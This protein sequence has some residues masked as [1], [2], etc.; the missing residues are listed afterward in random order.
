MN[1]L[2][3]ILLWASNNKTLQEKLPSVYF[4]KKAVNRFMPGENFEDAVT[5]AKELQKNGLGVVFTC[6]GENLTN[7]SEAEKVKDHY[8]KVLK[9]INKENLNAEISIKLTQLG[10]DLSTDKTIE[11][12]NELTSR[13]KELNNFVWIDMES[14]KYTQSTL[15][16]YKLIQ[17][18]YGN[19]GICLQ[20]YLIRTE[21]DV[22]ELIN[23][24]SSIRLVKGAYKE[25][26]DITLQSKSEVDNNYIKLSELLISKSSRCKVVFGTHDLKIINLLKTQIKKS[27]QSNVNYEFHLLYGIKTKEQLKLNKEGFNVK[28]LISYG[29]AWYPWYMR[30]L[31]ERPANIGFVL[32]NIFTR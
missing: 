19:C 25:L 17:N 6:L 16:F 28:V 7:L 18:Q 8:L 5:A 14:S 15:D 29:S 32:K 22:K 10:L 11:H 26:P 27:N 24:K 31:A 4:V 21:N 9:T 13:A 2:R 1:I 20:S 30:R 12:L 3:N 23:K